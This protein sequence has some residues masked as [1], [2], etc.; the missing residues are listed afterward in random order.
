MPP[1]AARTAAISVEA[2]TDLDLS[3]QDAAAF[4]ALIETRPDAGVFVS[5]AWLAGYFAEPPHAREPLLLL[6][7]EGGILRGVVPLA[8]HR[9][10]THVR[11]GLLGGGAGSDRVDLLAAAGYG[12]PCSEALL[13]WARS[14]WGRGGFVLELRDVPAESPVWGAVHRAIS[15]GAGPLAFTGHEVHTH[16]YIDLSAPEAPGSLEKHQRWLARRG[17]VR[18]EV[19]DAEDEV[20]EAFD[21]LT[22]FLRARFD[23][24]GTGSALDEPRA[25]RFHRRVLPL[26]LAEGR[27]RMIR[28]MVGGRIVAVFY[29]L[30]AGRWWGYYSAGY[31]RA[32]AGRIHLGRIMLDAAVEEAARQGSATFDF[33]K[34]GDR[35]KY[36]WPVRERATL[37]AD[38]WSPHAGAQFHRATCAA[39]ELAAACLKTV[40]HLAS[41]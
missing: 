3:A 1:P 25:A 41:I 8:L 21:H 39:R 29:G 6:F 32:W 10:L 11:I 14:S 27:L 38:V 20:A 17:E 2:R 33:L 24:P 30:A 5:R 26:L 9:A 35:M 40:R 13:A 28:L 23:G 7:R 16:L 36:A 22:R 31:D 34:G 4:D 12:A 15:E 37:D 19:L 18:V